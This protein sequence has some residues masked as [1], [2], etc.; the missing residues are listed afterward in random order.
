MF[1]HHALKLGNTFLLGL[2]SLLAGGTFFLSHSAAADSQGTDCPADWSVL[3]SQC[4]GGTMT[5][6]DANYHVCRV[7]PTGKCCTYERYD[8]YCNVVGYSK[9]HMGYQYTL[10][11]PGK[12]QASCNPTGYGCQ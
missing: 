11:G 12:T 2:I 9:T 8:V 6:E 5:Y 4:T 7:S 10:T 3:S 1:K